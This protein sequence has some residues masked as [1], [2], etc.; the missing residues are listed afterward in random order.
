MNIY[1]IFLK[2]KKFLSGKNKNKT[3]LR[4]SVVHGYI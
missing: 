2:D 4:S 1:I 3:I